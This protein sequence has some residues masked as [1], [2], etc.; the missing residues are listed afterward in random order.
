MTAIIKN[1]QVFLAAEVLTDTTANIATGWYNVP[2]HM[3]FFL[4]TISSSSSGTYTV[5]LTLETRFSD[6]PDNT[7]TGVLQ[8]AITGNATAVVHPSGV[9]EGLPRGDQMR[10]TSTDDLIATE[11]IT[12]S[13]IAYFSPPGTILTVDPS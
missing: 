10:I 6:D 5:T 8:E 4:E 13:V 2:A 3:G 12:L 9:I 1:R 7:V 11:T